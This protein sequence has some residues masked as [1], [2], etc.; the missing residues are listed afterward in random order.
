MIEHCL[1]IIHSVFL[2][3]M[4]VNVGILMVKILRSHEI[5]IYSARKIALSL[6]SPQLLLTN[7]VRL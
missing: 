7:N 4:N 2:N 3:K 6:Y 1:T 5:T